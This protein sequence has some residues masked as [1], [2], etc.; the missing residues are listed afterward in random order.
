MLAR[1]H[2]EMLWVT[3]LNE[4]FELDRFRLFVPPAAPGSR[5]GKACTLTTKPHVLLSLPA[6][7]CGK[8]TFCTLR[9]SMDSAF[10][11]ARKA[12][13]ILSFINPGKKMQSK[14]VP[15][16]HVLALSIASLFASGTAFARTGPAA[17]APSTTVVRCRPR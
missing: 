13:H 5:S 11:R 1:R 12:R 2:G 8:L 10:C 4:A 9:P 14:F 15:K 17:D 16:K 6:T 7:L 3:R